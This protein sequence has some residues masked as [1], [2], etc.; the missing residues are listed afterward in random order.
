MSGP[1]A[2][3]R[4]SYPLIACMCRRRSCPAVVVLEKTTRSV[5][6]CHKSAS[7]ATPATPVGLNEVRNEADQARLRLRTSLRSAATSDD[8]SSPNAAARG[9]LPA[10]GR[11]APAAAAGRSTSAVPLQQR[12]RAGDH[13]RC[14]RR[15]VAT[16]QA[17]LRGQSPSGRCLAPSGPARGAARH[18]SSAAAAATS[19]GRR[20]RRTVRR[21]CRE[22]G[23]RRRLGA[24]RSEGCIFC[25]FARR[26][27]C[28]IAARAGCIAGSGSAG[29]DGGRCAAVACARRAAASC[30]EP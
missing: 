23:G 4:F 15:N 26:R 3:S 27:A 24:A 14:V 20:P 5:G 21:R 8:A 10:H 29:S 12:G 22:R 16:P 11:G 28:Q 17:Q 18:N 2:S 6:M 7:S 13:G 25:A 1:M 9:P 30:W 19:P